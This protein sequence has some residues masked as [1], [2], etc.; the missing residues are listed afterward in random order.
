MVNNMIDT[1]S[2]FDDQVYKNFEVQ[3]HAREILESKKVLAFQ[4]KSTSGQ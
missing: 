4:V 1:M 2:L 3:I